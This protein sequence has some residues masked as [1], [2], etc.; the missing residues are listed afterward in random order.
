V[1]SFHYF[2]VH[3]IGPHYDEEVCKNIR[4]HLKNGLE[5]AYKKFYKKQDVP[6][7]VIFFCPASEKDCLENL[8]IA[9]LSEHGQDRKLVCK[10][11]EDRQDRKLV[12]R[13]GP[14]NLDPKHFV[15]LNEEERQHACGK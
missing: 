1:N 12:C 6:V 3:V 8:H 14:C 9:E 7:P 5:E 10:L 13:S 11:S 2:E 15:W 4:K